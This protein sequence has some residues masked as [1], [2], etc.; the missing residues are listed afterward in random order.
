MAINEALD[1][2]IRNWHTASRAYEQAGR[3]F[4]DAQAQLQHAERDLHELA[5]ALEVASGNGLQTNQATPAGT[6]T[7][8]IAPIGAP[9][10]GTDALGRPVITQPGATE[11]AAALVLEAMMSQRMGTGVG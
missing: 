9:G 3:L 1:T 11:D 10:I 2:A 4:N 8:P 6:V 5:R 7:M